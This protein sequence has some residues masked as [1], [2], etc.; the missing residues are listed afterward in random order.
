MNS[1]SLRNTLVAGLVAS[2][3][4]TAA[5]SNETG[6]IIEVTRDDSV[7]KDVQHL[8]FF[9]GVEYTPNDSLTGFVDDADPS[10]EVDVMGRDLLVDPYTLLLRKGKGMDAG[11]AVAV[12]AFNGDEMVG[13]GGLEASVNFVDGSVIQWGVT[14]KGD[15]V[16]RVDVTPT[17]CLV[18]TDADGNVV[19]I[20]HEDDRDCDGDPS[21]V[22]C[23][24]DDPKIG[25]SSPERCANQVDDNCNDV[26]DEEI[27]FDEDGVGN[28]SDCDDTD[29]DRTPGKTEVCDG[30]DNDCNDICD[31]GPLDGD[32]DNYTVC[33]RLILP[34]GTCSDVNKNLNDCKDNDEH[35]NPG[36][37]EVCDGKDNNCN[38]SC[39]EGFDEDLDT[40]TTCGSRT[41]QCNG[42]TRPADVDCE[43]TK[44]YVNPGQ[45]AELCDGY[46]TNCDGVL[47]PDTA[48]CYAFGDP[49][50]AGDACLV[51]ERYCD[52][53]IT[54]GVGWI[55]DCNTVDPV[56]GTVVVA[57]PLCVA[58]DACDDANAPDP[59]SCA[60]ESTVTQNYACTLAIRGGTICPNS[61][62]ILPNIAVADESCA[63]VVG[64]ADMIQ[65]Y[66]VGLKTVG[67][68]GT[69]PDITLN[70][71][72]ALFSVEG[73]LFPPP[74]QDKYVFY[75]QADDASQM[76]MVELTPN[77]VTD[78]PLNG[79]TC[80]QLVTPAPPGP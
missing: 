27:D 3:A 31:D 11:I 56:V 19:T 20:A 43:P 14:L 10:A 8:R 35:V 7:P 54:P 78:C 17:N 46:D 16:G 23:N 29:P 75:Q 64:P 21:D 4:L 48:P 71:C 1:L 72:A 67:S 38:E 55:N 9:V 45:P 30:K 52:E 24:D 36:Q 26:V 61:T 6:I 28:C 12:L 39:D 79:L 49:G 41:N 66:D 22:D 15:R 76:F 42:M 44:E 63:W 58:Y 37:E 77:P 70:D 65:T 47:Y 25:P 62:A 33:N 2:L 50:G 60:N 74:V 68:G 13:F 80:S 34:D 51:G 59:F 73:I 57:D 18:W 32:E 40:Y 5:C 69:P 53:S